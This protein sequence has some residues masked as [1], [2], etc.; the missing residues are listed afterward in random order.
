MKDQDLAKEKIIVALDVPNVPQAVD[1]VNRLAAEARWFKIGLELFTAAGPSIVR[2]VRDR[3]AKIFLDL[4]LH[5]IPNTVQGAA[6]AISRLGVDMFTVH[7][8]GGS[9]MC[10]AAV[11][12]AGGALVLGVTV[13]TSQD[14]ESLRTTGIPASIS[15]QVLLLAKLAKQAGVPGLVASPG[16]LRILR[17]EFGS[18][19]RVVTPG[20]RPMLTPA[21]D[22]KRI[23]TP[24]EAVLAGTDY[25]VIGRPIIAAPD[26]REALQ[27]IVE[28]VSGALQER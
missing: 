20:I 5:D 18:H 17:E 19:F 26:P 11:K 3:G 21:G 27:R 4:K 8:A 7:L 28:E 15:A 22:Q 12:A 13:L 1:L 9:E 2:E 6:G 16:E 23:T 25:L 14:E 10:E 24:R